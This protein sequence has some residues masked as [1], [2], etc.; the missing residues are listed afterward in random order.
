MTTNRS[1]GF[2]NLGMLGQILLA[3]VFSPLWFSV[4]HV[5]TAVQR[6]ALVT[7]A[8]LL[9]LVLLMAC[10]ALPCPAATLLAGPFRC[11][12]RKHASAKALFPTYNLFSH[13]PSEVV[14]AAMNP[15]KRKEVR[16][17]ACC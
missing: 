11:R 16:I 9:F 5:E 10:R 17:S 2:F 6:T 4:S 15:K 13:R 1:R 14:H 8:G 3:V 7:V 12:F